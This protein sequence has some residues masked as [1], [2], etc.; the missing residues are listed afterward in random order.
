MPGTGRA[1][2]E[3]ETVSARPVPEEFVEA[4]TKRPE[5]LR[6]CLVQGGRLRNWNKDWNNDWNKEALWQK[7]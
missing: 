6:R 1:L 4:C 5:I 2:T 3:L 7:Q